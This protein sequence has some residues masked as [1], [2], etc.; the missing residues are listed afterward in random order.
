MVYIFWLAVGFCG[1][2]AASWLI[3]KYL[4]HGILWGI[5]QTHHR[6]SRHFLE[7]N[8]VF[9]L[10]FGGVS[11]W[12]IVDGVNTLAPTFWI[13]L[14]IALYGLLYFIL[15]DVL[16]HRRVRTPFKPVNRYLV[17]ITKAH[18]MHHKSPERDG[19]ESFG[20]LLVH[21]KY[22]RK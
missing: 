16:I 4:M 10:M 15:H 8:D 20:L 2:E 18:Q 12:L 19:A 14:G 11:V 7:L 5:H 17:A 6:K 3:H 9:S 22:F 21:P 13:G 1:M